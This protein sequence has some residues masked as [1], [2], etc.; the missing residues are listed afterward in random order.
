MFTN[1]VIDKTGKIAIAAMLR[2]AG[3]CVSTEKCA[4]SPRCVFA[5]PD[6]P[7]TREL[8]TTFER[9]EIVPVPQRAIWDAYR[10]LLAET[11]AKLAGRIGGTYE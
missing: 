5:F 9:S 4:C 6:T 11:K 1:E 3:Y 7:E 2:G 10:A 8:I